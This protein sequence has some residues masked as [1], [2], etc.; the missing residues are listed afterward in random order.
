MQ[1]GTFWI[2]LVVNLGILPGIA[3]YFIKQNQQLIQKLN[4][5][6]NEREQSLLNEVKA[7][8]DFVRTTL[9]DHLGEVKEVAQRSAVALEQNVEVLRRVQ[10]QREQE[11]SSS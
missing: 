6:A 9:L 5:A 10:Y 7:N 8:N 11:H 2:D 1:D 3:F 4:D